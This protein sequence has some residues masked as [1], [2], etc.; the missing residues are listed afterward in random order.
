MHYVSPF[1]PAGTS[2]AIAPDR[3]RDQHPGAVVLLIAQQA[4]QKDE[5]AYGPSLYGVGP[6]VLMA[7]LR[8]ATGGECRREL[9]M[10]TTLVYVGAMPHTWRHKRATIHTSAAS[11]PRGMGYL[12][13]HPLDSLPAVGQSVVRNPHSARPAVAQRV[14]G[15]HACKGQASA[16]RAK[17]F[18][19]SSRARL[20]SHPL[21]CSGR[22][23]SAKSSASPQQTGAGC[24]ECRA[25]TTA[26][27]NPSGG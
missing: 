5:L 6:L 21:A 4:T 23:C 27:G 16:R 2:V 22:A 13:R 14:D 18:Y 24:W 1:S 7:D 9:L 15:D 10:C 20:Y 25:L 19:K 3:Q 26:I 11:R 8:A 12:G 17:G